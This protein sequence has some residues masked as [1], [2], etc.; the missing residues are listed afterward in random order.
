MTVHHQRPGTW[1]WLRGAGGH[2]GWGA[3]GQGRT[4]T[5]K[6]KENPPPPIPLFQCGWK[7]ESGS[8]TMFWG[9]S[10]TCNLS[11]CL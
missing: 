10:F 3:S 9:D 5:K 2:E 7:P 4:R 8:Q 1:M 6:W 11:K